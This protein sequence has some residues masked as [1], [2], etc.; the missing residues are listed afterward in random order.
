FRGGFLTLGLARRRSLVRFLRAFRTGGGHGGRL[1]RWFVCNVFRQDLVADAGCGH[2]LRLVAL[3]RVVGI[4]GVLGVLGVVTFIVLF[5][6]FAD[7]E[8]AFA[9]FAFVVI[10]LSGLFAASRLPLGLETASEPLGTRVRRCLLGGFGS[11]FLIEESLPV[12]HR[13]LVVVRMNF[14]E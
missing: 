12:R 9:A 14:V 3:I 8:P 5:A 13:D 6:V 4:L 2:G 11:G 10:G 7:L 1:I